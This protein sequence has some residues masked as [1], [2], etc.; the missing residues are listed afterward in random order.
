MVLAY[1]CDRYKAEMRCHQSH[2]SVHKPRRPQQA[3]HSLSHRPCMMGYV[4][5]S[6]WLAVGAWVYEHFDEIGG[7]SF[8]PYSDHIY[9]QAPYTP[10]TKEEY[11]KA[12]AAF[13]NIDW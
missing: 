11:D 1:R 8:L 5:E 2:R 4:K 3:I 6:E 13:P 7:I 10:I 9:K 12:V